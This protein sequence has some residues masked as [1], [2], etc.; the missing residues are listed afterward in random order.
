L[1]LFTLLSGYILGGEDAVVRVN[2]EKGNESLVTRSTL[3][4]QCKWSDFVTKAIRPG[5]KSTLVCAHRPKCLKLLWIALLSFEEREPKYLVHG[6][7]TQS[8]LEWVKVVF[9]L[10]G[11]TCIGDILNVVVV[12]RHTGNMLI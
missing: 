3:V 6:I 5:E 4:F 12:P 7:N 2:Q 11:N 1:P 10:E 8:E 9:L